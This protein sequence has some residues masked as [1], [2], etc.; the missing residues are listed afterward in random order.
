MTGELINIISVGQCGNRLGKKFA[1]LGISSCYINS[2]SVDMRGL[3]VLPEKM[4]LVDGRGTGGNPMQGQRM[5]KSY[6][7]DIIEFVMKHADKSRLNLVVFGLGGGTGGSLG[8]AILELLIA[9]KYKTGC[10]ATLPQKILGILAG[11]NAMRT[12]KSIKD[13]PM[14]LFALADNEFL[15]NSIG[16]STNWWERVNEHIV[17]NVVSAFGI[18]DPTKVSQTGIGSIDKGELLRILQY[19]KGLTD[20]RTIYLTLS[21]MYMDE[22]ELKARLYAPS[23]I[24]GFD[25]KETLAY[26]VAID[27][28][29]RG[30]YTRVAKTVFDVTKA[31]AGSAI[32]RIGMFTDGN[33]S[34]SIRI[35][36][37]NAGMRLPKVL[38][39]RINNLKRDEQRFIS[40][41]S[42][43]E[44]VLDSLD[45]DGG[46][47]DEDFK[48]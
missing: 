46:L 7:A 35:T 13:M 40:K 4:F 34:D 12:L 10:L 22:K 32:S 19:G 41:K 48:L 3:N 18:L 44:D 28:P 9:K 47:L 26:L 42:K 27:T 16:V 30:D 23:S 25:Y 38:Q 39:S 43:K 24:Q 15:I 5:Y 36:L 31:V 20:I 14:N 11:D 37:I 29:P 2:D 21:E 45:M 33:L 6:K 1:T 8:P 17:G